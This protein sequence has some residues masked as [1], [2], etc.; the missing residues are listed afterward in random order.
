[1]RPPFDSEVGEHN[2]KTMVDDTQIITVMVIY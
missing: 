2:R 1:V